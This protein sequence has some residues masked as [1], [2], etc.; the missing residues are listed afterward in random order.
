MSGEVS[1]GG[2][3]PELTGQPGI[4]TYLIDAALNYGEES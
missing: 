4:K 1:A 2:A 3:L